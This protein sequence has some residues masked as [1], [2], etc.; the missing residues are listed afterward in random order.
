MRINVLF[1]VITIA[2]LTVSCMNN[3]NKD[4]KEESGQQT[5]DITVSND[6]ESLYDHI[7]ASDLPDNVFDLIGKQWMLVTAGNK[8]FYNTMT[9]NRVPFRSLVLSHYH[10]A[11]NTGDL[12]ELCGYGIHTFRHI[13]FEKN[14]CLTIDLF[15]I[16]VNVLT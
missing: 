9:A 4:K 14:D 8:E 3:S 13:F 6:W 15:N 7:E 11:N 10:K 2:T 1:P 16:P 12:A 5:E